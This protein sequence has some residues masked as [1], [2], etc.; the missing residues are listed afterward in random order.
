MADVYVVTH[1]RLP[2]QFALKVMRIDGSVREAL[3]ERFKREGEILAALKHPPSTG[4]F[5][6]ALGH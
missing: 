1:T 5:G 3:L 4:L 2:R 6:H